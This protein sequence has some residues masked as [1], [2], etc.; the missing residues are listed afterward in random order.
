MKSPTIGTWPGISFFYMSINVEIQKNIFTDFY[1]SVLID[2][3]VY[4]KIIT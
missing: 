4:S 3:Y 1:F 2:S